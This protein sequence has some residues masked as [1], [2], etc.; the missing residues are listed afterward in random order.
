M[1]HGGVSVSVLAAL[2]LFY[3]GTWEQCVFCEARAQ[4]N[5]LHA[6]LS[7]RR[8]ET[9]PPPSLRPALTDAD[10]MILIILHGEMM[11]MSNRCCRALFA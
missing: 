9:R 8:V 2:V 5:S 11:E 1:E 10:D 6:S 4:R 3:N 7:S